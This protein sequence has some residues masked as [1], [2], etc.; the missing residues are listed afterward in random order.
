MEYLE[1]VL[2]QF[3]NY[4]PAFYP[5]LKAIILLIQLKNV[6]LDKVLFQLTFFYLQ[7]QL[8]LLGTFQHRC[9]LIFHYRK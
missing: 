2:Y 9:I 6:L 7:F 1:E 5:C 8:M 3:E 4:F